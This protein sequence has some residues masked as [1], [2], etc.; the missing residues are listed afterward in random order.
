MHIGYPR[1]SRLIDEMHELGIVG[2]RES[3]GRPRRVLELSAD[4]PEATLS[5]EQGESGAAGSRR[6]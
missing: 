6:T 3:G 1:A 2:P 5:G 4:R